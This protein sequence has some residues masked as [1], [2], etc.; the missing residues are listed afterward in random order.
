MR[1]LR[2]RAIRGIRLCNPPE[3]RDDFGIIELA[4][5]KSIISARTSVPIS[6]IG[7]TPWPGNPWVA[8]VPFSHRRV[9]RCVAATLAM[10]LR[11]SIGSYTSEL[12][13]P[14]RRREGISQVGDARLSG[15][16]L[17]QSPG[18]CFSADSRRPT[19]NHSH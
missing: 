10:E 3:K 11:L 15:I 5:F 6:T 13:E 1:L 19:S 2:R 14:R 18:P 12:Y 4:R 7:G 16:R 17:L 8:S 9:A